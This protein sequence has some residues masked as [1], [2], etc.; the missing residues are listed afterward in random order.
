MRSVTLKAPAK[1]NL[2]LSIIKKLKNGYHEIE[3]IFS[4]VSLFDRIH[5]KEI[6]EDE[7]RVFC[8]D[9]NVPTDKFNTVYQAAMLLKKLGI[10]KGVEVKIEKKIPVGSGLGGGSADAA[11]TLL[12]LNKL[13]N[14]G[15]NTKDLMK[16]GIKIGADVCYQ[17]VG[18]TKLGKHLGEKLTP[19]PR[20]PKTTIIL[21]NPG[22]PIESKWAYEHVEEN[23]IGKEQIKD[24]LFAIR[25]KSIKAVAQNLHND[26]E[27]WVPNF[28]PVISKIKKKMLSLGAMG[29]AMTGSGSTV[30][31]LCP[32]YQTAKKIY[33]KLKKEYSRTYLVKTL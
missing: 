19:L 29:A 5:L 3:S 8:D 23:K 11:Q 31:G 17:L 30:Y 4:Q 32:N 18:G 10:K 22:V 16:L 24:L 21:C 33:Q 26:F 9:K 28:Y 1:I 15:L 14:L 13:W 7:I 6:P 20:L 27:F 25:A 2:G 12:G